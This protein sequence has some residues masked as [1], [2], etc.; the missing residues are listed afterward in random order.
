MVV[1]DRLDVGTTAPE[2]TPVVVVASTVVVD[3]VDTTVTGRVVVASNVVLVGGT[4][5]VVEVGGTVVVVEVGGTVVVVVVTLTVVVVEV[6][7]GG[8]VVVLA[9]QWY[10]KESP[11]PDAAPPSADACIGSRNA[12][13]DRASGPRIRIRERMIRPRRGL[14]GRLPTRCSRRRRR[15][16]CPSP[17]RRSTRTPRIGTNR[18]ASHHHRSPAAR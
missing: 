14:P 3:D 17:G 9:G 18:R 1:V 15:V 2:P 8:R 4:I 7:L 6:V 11:Q 16:A 10:D 13:P 5:V 12:T